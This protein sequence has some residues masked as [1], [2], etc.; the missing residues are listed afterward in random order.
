M[1][2]CDVGSDAPWGDK[3]DFN[4]KW[5]ALHCETFGDGVE[6]SLGGTIQSIPRGRSAEGKIRVADVF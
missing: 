3:H 1:V 5:L 2:L 4:A 6:R